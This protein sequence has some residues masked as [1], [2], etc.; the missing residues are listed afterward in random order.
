MEGPE[1]IDLP[2]DLQ[3]DGDNTEEAEDPESAEQGQDR[4]PEDEPMP[5][6][7]QDQAVTDEAPDNENQVKATF[8]AQTSLHLPISLCNR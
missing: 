3:L 2:E 6:R 1:E 4:E 5:D 8:F 7:P